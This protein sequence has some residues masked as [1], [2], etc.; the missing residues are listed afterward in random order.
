MKT[1]IASAFGLM[2]LTSCDLYMVE[3][4]YRHDYRDDIVGHYHLDEYSE[5]YHEYTY[6]AVT[7]TEGYGRREINIRNFYGLGRDVTAY[8]DGHT[9]TIPFQVINGYEIEGDGQLIYD[10]L[11]LHYSVT[12]RYDDSPTDFCDTEGVRADY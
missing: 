1:F 3:E 7:I 2:L 4:P 6:Y 12:D 11:D 5:T 8:V 9:I 10:K